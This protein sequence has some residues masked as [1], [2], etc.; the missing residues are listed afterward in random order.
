MNMMNLSRSIKCHKVEFYGRFCLFEHNLSSFAF[1]SCVTH[2]KFEVFDDVLYPIVMGNE[3]KTSQ[4][5]KSGG[6][7]TA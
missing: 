1:V 5:L 3:A 6:L 4:I 2:T 7:Y